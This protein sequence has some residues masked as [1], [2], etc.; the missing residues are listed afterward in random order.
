MG[1]YGTNYSYGESYYKDEDSAVDP[2]RHEVAMRKQ[3]P[4]QI[5]KEDPIFVNNFHVMGKFLDYCEDQG[6][7]LLDDLF[8]DTTTLLMESF[9]ETYNLLVAPGDSDTI[10][11]NRIEA[12]VRARGGLTKAYYES[13][14][15]KLGSGIYTVSLAEGTGAIGFVIHQYSIHTSP[16]G[17]GTPLP[18]PIHNGPF[19]SSCY[20]ITVT[21][22]GAASAPELENMYERLKPAWT[23]FE[24]TY[25]P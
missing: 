4:L 2:F 13:L 11:R 8:P 15:N 20:L 7:L 5:L 19:G 17:P 12:A 14:G 25:V 1:D 10:R 21:V 16:Q 18:A 24:Y 6:A 23:K 9:E 22:T 3:S